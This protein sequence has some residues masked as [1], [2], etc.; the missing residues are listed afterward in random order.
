MYF[1]AKGHV[2]IH[3]VYSDGTK[4]HAAIAEDAL[5]AGL[6]YVIT[7]DHNVWVDGVE[8][9][10]EGERHQKLLLLVGEEVHDVRREPQANHCLIFGADAELARYAADPQHLIEAAAEAGGFCFLA[11]PFEVGAEL[12]H[13]GELDAINW[14]DWNVEHYA[15]LEI[16]NY[17]SEFKSHLTGQLAAVRAAY[18]P[19][20]FITGPFQ[21]TVQKWDELL[22]K[23]RRVSCIGGG[24]VHGQAYTLGPLTR[25]LFPYQAHFHTLNTHLLTIKPLTG[26]L[27]EDK[28][29]VLRALRLGNAW[30][31]YDAAGDT[32]G[33]RFSAQGLKRQAIM[34]QTLK[35]KR[36]Q[37]TM[38]VTTPAAGHIQLLCNGNVIAET[39]GSCHL[40]Y[41]TEEPGAYRAQVFRRYAGRK[42]GWI[43]SNPI[44]LIP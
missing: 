34:G 7:T 27:E 9:Y 31:G 10:Y 44:Y 23:G 25:I 26:D 36:N 37:A 18:R 28:Q 42:R 20:R 3:T 19:E 14:E 13:D 30:V 41:Q 6:D 32:T 24:D 35:L 21:K 33:F 4:S 22:G 15:G 38:Q 1:E 16:W 39:A 43:Y 2:H 8:G 29:M 17:M 5:A 11:H 12:A 40:L